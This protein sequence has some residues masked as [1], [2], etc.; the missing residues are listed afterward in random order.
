[1]GR[2]LGTLVQTRALRSRPHLQQ[3]ILARARKAQ[4][5][6]AG[7]LSGWGGRRPERAGGHRS[8]RSRHGAG[9]R[10]GW[11]GPCQ[12]SRAAALGLLCSRARQEGPG[13]ALQRHPSARASTGQLRGAPQACRAIPQPTDF[14]PA[15]H[16]GQRV[17]WDVWPA[18]GK[19]LP[20]PAWHGPTVWPGERPDRPQ[21]GPGSPP[22]TGK[23]VPVLQTPGNPRSGEPR[24]NPALLAGAGVPLG[25][26]V[27]GGAGGGG[28][29]GP[30]G[31][32]C[33]APTPPPGP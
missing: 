28:S 23:G 21:K 10:D 29:H 13:C 26:G 15:S 3:T 11:G 16:Q 20:C 18:P 25:F 5:G 31:L 33:A 30:A 8:D 1:M 12:E 17:P 7:E 27:P 24:S 2:L 6:G 9:L 14:R 32:R 22:S 4:P 19:A